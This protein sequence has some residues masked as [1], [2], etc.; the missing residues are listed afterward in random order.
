MV[1]WYMF[2]GKH[3]KGFT[4][5][6]VLLVIAILSVVGALGAG[7]YRNFSK[8]VTLHATTKNVIFDL[9]NARS[10]AMIGEDGVR[11][12]IHFVNGSSDYYELFSTL[13]DYAE[14]LVK[15]TV[16]FQGGILF[17]SPSEGESFDVLF[18]RISGV[19]TPETVVVESEDDN[20][21]ITI[22][23]IGNVY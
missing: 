22:T 19:S 13:T 5:I 12:G 11:W 17:T 18:E 10:K 16:V 7:F 15:T 20:R 23:T 9:R 14:G 2:Y 21:T 4:L 3:S 6:E 8:G 1:T